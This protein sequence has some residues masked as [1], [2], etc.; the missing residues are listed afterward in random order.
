M[1]NAVTN[2]WKDVEKQITFECV[3]R[4]HMYSCS[5]F[6][7]LSGKPSICGCCALYDVFHQFTLIFDEICKEKYMWTGMG[8]VHR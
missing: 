7:G 3:S 6:A 2:G 8:I 4:R 5:G 1:Y